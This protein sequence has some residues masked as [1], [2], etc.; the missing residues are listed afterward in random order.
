VLKIKSVEPDGIGSELG[1][2]PGDIII[3]INGCQARD[4]IDYYFHMAG[5]EVALR[6]K[7][8]QG[9]VEIE[10]EKD[11]EE[12]LGLE[13]EL[14]ARQCRNKCVFCFID[15]QPRG[16]RK[17]LYIKDD[18]YRLSFLH[19]NY[20]TL[21]N[22]NPK[23]IL[24]ITTEGISPLYVSVHTTDP[25]ARARLLGREGQFDVLSILRNLKSNS[26]DF[27]GQIV[28]C[29]GYNDSEIL[30]RTL[31]DL[32]ALGESLLS[33]A[34]VPVGLTRHRKKL[35]TVRAVDR[36]VATDTI[37]L[38]DTYQAR[39]LKLYG[40]RVV[41]AAD[42]FYIKAQL[43]IPSQDYY[44]DY[45]QL[46]NG[47]GL[48]RRMLVQAD[49]L[50]VQ[51]PLVSAK[52]KVLLMT[53]MAAR[54]TLELVSKDIEAVFPNFS[55]E[56]QAVENRFLG[57]QITVAGLLAG[58]DIYETAARFDPDWDIMLVPGVAVRAGCFIDDYTLEQLA[59]AF[60]RPVFAPED[61]EELVTIL[62]NEVF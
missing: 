46:E 37:R 9:L 33:L 41:F 2:V 29:P 10:I 45:A 51:R 24:R 36:E 42:E 13:F 35:A 20:I 49:E 56:V 57:A 59:T 48:I 47:I 14:R 12:D 18:D 26:I 44:E 58:A 40:R 5:E 22:L 17:T 8:A 60:S 16:M 15:Q 32:S 61:L 39:F 4:L 11:Y 23:D 53:S 6:L 1:F 28:L 19:G 43:P 38:I 55:I 52:K 27:H 62:R 30:A 7:T 25:V 34:V 3:A 54:P 21:T 31:E 50:A